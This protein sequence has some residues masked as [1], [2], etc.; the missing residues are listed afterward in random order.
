[1]TTPDVL[2]QPDHAPKRIQ[3][4][5][6]INLGHVL[7]FVGFLVVGFGAWGS[8]DKRLT[9]TEL[10]GNAAVE[11]ASEQDK[12]IKESLQELKADIKDVQRAVTDM[13]RSLAIAGKK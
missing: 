6:T 10:Q 8:V 1:M 3:F 4:D 7:T 12:R 2:M 9:V 11:R 5:P 13:N